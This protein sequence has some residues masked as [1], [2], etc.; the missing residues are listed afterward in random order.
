MIYSN[1][2]AA[3]HNT[4]SNTAANHVHCHYCRTPTVVGAF[5]LSGLRKWACA[6]CYTIHVIIPRTCSIKEL[7]LVS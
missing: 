3:N 4:T 5:Y 2:T 1:N 7:V 6:E